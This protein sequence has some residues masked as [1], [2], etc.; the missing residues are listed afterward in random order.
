V[1]T[2]NTFNTFIAVYIVASRRHGTIYIGVTSNLIKRI[3]QHRDGTYEGFTKTYGVHRLAWYQGH[4][5]MTSAIRR[6]KLI[7]SY[8]REWKINLIEAENPY[9]LD[10]YPA[11]IGQWRKDVETLLASIETARDVGSK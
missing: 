10:L 2:R 8:K 5:E 9:W 1:V 6:E 3:Q 4:S 11:L 7:K